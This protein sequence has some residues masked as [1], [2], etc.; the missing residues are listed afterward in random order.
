MQEGSML[1]HL[2][3]NLNDY[4]GFVKANQWEW[5]E[6][7]TGLP[8]MVRQLPSRAGRRNKGFRNLG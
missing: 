5:E 4:P 7:S 1:I 3:A 2:D 8:A 6:N